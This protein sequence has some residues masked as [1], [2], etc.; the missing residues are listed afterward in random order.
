MD[1][2]SADMSLSGTSRKPR[3]RVPAMVV[4]VVTLLVLMAIGLVGMGV[5]LVLGLLAGFTLAGLRADAGGIARRV[6]NA[7]LGLA[8]ACTLLVLVFLI[9]SDGRMAD[10]DVVKAAMLSVVLFGIPATLGGGLAWLI[11]R[12][13]PS[14]PPCAS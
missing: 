12:R 5:G 8:L 3:F 6:R 1:E 13:R 2:S 4:D 11:R 9:L 10:E 14:P 7:W